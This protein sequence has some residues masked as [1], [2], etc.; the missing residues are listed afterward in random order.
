MYQWHAVNWDAVFRSKL[1]VVLKYYIESTDVTRMD[2]LCR[3]MKSLEYIFKF[4]IRSR[5]LFAACVCWYLCFNLLWKKN[6]KTELEWLLGHQ[7]RTC[8]TTTNGLVLQ[9]VCNR[10]SLLYNILMTWVI[11]TPEMAEEQGWWRYSNFGMFIGSIIKHCST[12][13]TST[14]KT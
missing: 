11:F 3:A 9:H 14:P 1:M 7:L 6:K 4:I 13:F 8:C 12:C 2:S 5:F 10:L